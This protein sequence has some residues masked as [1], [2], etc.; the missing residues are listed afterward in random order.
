MTDNRI[1]NNVSVT[2]KIDKEL[3]FMYTGFVLIKKLHVVIAFIAILI[4][5]TVQIG[6]MVYNVNKIYD[7]INSLNDRVTVVEGIQKE[8]G[9]RMTEQEMYNSMSMAEFQFN[10][11]VLMEKN[12]LA[13]KRFKVTETK[14]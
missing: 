2:P 9:V 13:Y 6:G 10:L 5:T 8:R 7:L 11:E 14:K 3:D 12:G 4:I 1:E